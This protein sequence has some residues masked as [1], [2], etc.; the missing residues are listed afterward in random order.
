MTHRDPYR[1]DEHLQTG[2]ALQVDP[3]VR[4][5]ARRAVWSWITGLAIVFI[6]FIVF[7]GLNNSRDSGT[8]TSAVPPAAT[9]SAPTTTGQGG[10]P[11][12]ARNDAA[13]Q[14]GAPANEG[15]GGR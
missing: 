1:D 12:G 11:S 13:E 5:T 4:A 6:L 15:A 2:R 7:Y 10:S 14:R 8:V 9:T 3:T